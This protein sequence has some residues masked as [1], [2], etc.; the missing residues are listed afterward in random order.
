MYQ[1]S[2]LSLVKEEMVDFD[3]HQELLVA[4]VKEGSAVDLPP[5]KILQVVCLGFPQSSRR[6]WYEREFLGQAPRKH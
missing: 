3:S 6:G 1:K 2:H 5:Q 4:E